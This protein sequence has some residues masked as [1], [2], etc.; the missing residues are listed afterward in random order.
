MDIEDLD[1][2]ADTAPPSQPPTVR[3][4]AEHTELMSFVVEPYLLP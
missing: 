1:D 2:T 4:L 3:L